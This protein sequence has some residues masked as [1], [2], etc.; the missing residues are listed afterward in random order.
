MAEDQLSVAEI[1]VLT[2]R[3]PQPCDVA[4]DPLYSVRLDAI[5][6]HAARQFAAELSSLLRRTVRVRP[7]GAG[8]E[9]YADFIARLEPAAYRR[10]IAATSLTEPWLVSISPGTLYSIVDCMLGGGREAQAKGQRPPTDIEL[11]LVDRAVR[12]FLDALQSAWQATAALELA[13]LEGEVNAPPAGA[14]QG[15]TL[16]CARFTLE[17]AGARGEMSLGVSL[18]DLNSLLTSPND[19]VVAKERQ[20]VAG[21][22]ETV[23]LVACLAETDIEPDELASLAVGDII[24][25]E[26]SAAG[27]IAVSHDGELIFHA[28]LGSRR[29]HK[30]IEIEHVLPAEDRARINPA[31]NE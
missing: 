3:R 13:I 9:P 2:G 29:G 14:P 20:P 8:P 31:P 11:R 19:C 23:E 4:L 10:R 22:H 27:P 16:H 15:S 17:F 25:T 7:S 26:Q 6:E 1:E 28:H 5:H 18:K 12:P 21:D 30:A 24:T